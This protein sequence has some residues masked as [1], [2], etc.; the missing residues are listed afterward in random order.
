MTG[1]TMSD[2]TPVVADGRPDVGNRQTADR[3]L[4]CMADTGA[5]LRPSQGGSVAGR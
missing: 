2:G 3:V 1:S 4:A 5:H